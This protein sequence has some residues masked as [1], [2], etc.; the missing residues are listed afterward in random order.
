[1]GR[2]YIINYSAAATAAIDLIQIQSHST[3]VTK[4]CSI[5]V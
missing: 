3:K 4:V 1:M 5:R 2:K